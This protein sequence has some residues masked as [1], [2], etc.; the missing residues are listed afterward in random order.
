MTDPSEDADPA[1]AGTAANVPAGSSGATIADRDGGVARRLITRCRIA[2]SVLLAIAVLFL[3]IGVL[4]MWSFSSALFV[5]LAVGAL[6]WAAT[7]SRRV[8]LWSSVALAPIAGV[9]VGREATTGPPKRLSPGIPGAPMKRRLGATVIP[10]HT[11]VEPQP[12][13]GALVVHA[14]TDRIALT[15]VKVVCPGRPGRGRIDAT[16]AGVGSRPDRDDQVRAV[17]ALPDIGRR[18]VS[19][20]HPPVRHV[21]RIRAAGTAPTGSAL[22]CERSAAYLVATEPAAGRPPSDGRTGPRSDPAASRIRPPRGRPTALRRRRRGRSPRPDRAP[23][24]ACARCHR[25]WSPG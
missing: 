1:L 8:R 9:V 13:G 2:A 25:R 3:L 17:R 21:V 5:L 7:L 15:G 16:A 11:A 19:G 12:G 4:R 6:A 20:H 14:R 18:R 24:A 23:P 10:I 22:S